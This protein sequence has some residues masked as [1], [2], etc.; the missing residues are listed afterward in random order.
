MLNP[1]EK[2]YCLAMQ[3]LQRKDYRV[4]EA[5]FEKAAPHFEQNREFNLFRES[6]QLLVAVQHE[7]SELDEADNELAIEEV[8]SDGQETVVRR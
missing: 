6:T 4:A 5:H 2:A 7:L 1:A 8:F 3:A